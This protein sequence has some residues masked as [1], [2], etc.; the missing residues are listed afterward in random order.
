[1]VEDSNT[2]MGTTPTTTNSS[3]ST[4]NNNNTNN[5]TNNNHR[6]H[7]SSKKDQNLAIISSGDKDFKGVCEDF[8]LVIGLATETASLKHGKIYSEFTEHLLTHVQS[9]YTRGNDLRVLIHELENPLTALLAKEPP[10]PPDIDDKTGPST[11]SVKTWEM[12]MK[13]HLD[14]KELLE[15]NTEKRYL[16]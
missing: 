10:Y 15:E 13:R 1:M 2:P 4:N 9:N 12:K 14:R 3:T 6:G 5:T 16:D 7:R 8:G 11:A